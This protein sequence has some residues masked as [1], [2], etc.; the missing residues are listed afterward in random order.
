[1]ATRISRAA[2]AADSETGAGADVDADTDADAVPLTSS[3]P[4]P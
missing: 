2:R 1:M 4:S 3:I